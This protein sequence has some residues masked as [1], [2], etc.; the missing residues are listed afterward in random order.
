M[1]DL[2]RKAPRPSRRLARASALTLL[3]LGMAATAETGITL[4]VR[5]GSSNDLALLLAEEGDKSPAD[6]FLS[7]S[8]GPAGFLDDLGMLATL[9][10]RRD[11]DPIPNRPS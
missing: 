2:L 1:R 6:V 4:E 9:D 10:A 5:Y 8:P 11:R 7:R 3:L